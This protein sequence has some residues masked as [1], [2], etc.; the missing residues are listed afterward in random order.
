MTIEPG[1][2]HRAFWL[3]RPLLNWQDV[4]RWAIEAGAIYMVKPEEL[5]ATLVTV[6]TCADWSL[7]ER[8]H[9]DVVEVDA[10]EK[11]MAHLGKRAH[12]MTFD[13]DALHARWMSIAALMLVDHPEGFTG[14][15]T[16]A[17]G[18]YFRQPSRP[19]DGKLIFGPEV[20]APL[21][22]NFTP[23]D[24]GPINRRAIREAIGLPPGDIR[25]I[26][27]HELDTHPVANSRDRRRQAS[28]MKQIENLDRRAMAA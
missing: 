15:V 18:R 13:H 27:Q 10:G 17:R 26:L 19:Y 3:Y 7:L 2:R 22:W 20:I 16:L 14:H 12:G 25:S 1:R 23:P 4:Y 5:H 11:P 24:G 6:R 28:L 8:L 9:D 21:N